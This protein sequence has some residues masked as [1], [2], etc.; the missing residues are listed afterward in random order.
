MSP[1]SAPRSAPRPRTLLA[2]GF[3]LGMTACSLL[4]NTNKDQC[5]ADA[6]CASSAGAVCREG[7]CVLASS[8]PEAGADAPS[9]GPNGPD[10]DAG[11]TPKVPTSDPDFLNE[12][13]T[14]AQCID[15]DNCT[16]LGVCDGG[17]PPL[18]TPPVGGI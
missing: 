10:G 3:A 17:L 7:V 18:V 15:F 2:V 8:L 6:D 5:S 1:T 12:K 11:C 14:N 4:V 13:C 9:D 16:R